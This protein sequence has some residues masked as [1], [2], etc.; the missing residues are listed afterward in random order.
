MNDLI[1]WMSGSLIMGCLKNGNKLP[2]H[3]FTVDQQNLV[4][5]VTMLKLQIDFQHMVVFNTIVKFIVYIISRSGITVVAFGK[6]NL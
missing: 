3:F 1:G 5:V 4:Q 6:L 2:Y